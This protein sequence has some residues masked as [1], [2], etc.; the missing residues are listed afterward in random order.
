MST[1]LPQGFR[2]GHAGDLACPHRDVTTCAVCQIEHPEIIVIGGQAFWVPDPE[3]QR[4]IAALE[5]KRIQRDC[6]DRIEKKQMSL[7]N[8]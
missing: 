6:I 1:G 7:F 5:N 2:E 4:E 8:K 3:E